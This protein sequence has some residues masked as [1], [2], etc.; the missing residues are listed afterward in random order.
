[1]WHL[2]SQ[3]KEENMNERKMGNESYVS[4]GVEDGQVEVLRAG[5]SGGHSSHHLGSVL[6]RLL[7]V[8]GALLKK[9]NKVERKGK[10]EGEK[11]KEEELACFPVN[12]WQMTL[13]LAPMLRFT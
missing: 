11:K 4:D 13:V 6:N 5:L 2:A 10:S 7:R 3:K 12:P 9:K 8:E 1:M